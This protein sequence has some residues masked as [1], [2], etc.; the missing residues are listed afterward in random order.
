MMRELRQISVLC[1]LVWSLV[2]ASTIAQDE[3]ET[4]GSLGTGELL[5][6]EDKPTWSELYA[7]V[8]AQ[9]QSLEPR[10]EELESLSRPLNK[11]EKEELAATYDRLKSQFDELRDTREEAIE[12]QLQD[13]E[14]SRRILTRIEV[15]LEK[16]R[17]FA[18][19]EEARNAPQVESMISNF[20]FYG[21][22][23]ARGFSHGDGERTLDDST[24][25]SVPGSP[26]IRK[27]PRSPRRF[28][29]TSKR[30]KN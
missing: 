13:A 25:V 12:Q 30:P 9:L 7:V 15:L 4:P 17:T 8:M 23:R 2:P 20:A 19:P 22:I 6:D 1:V 21:S 5:L 28:E 24:S 27:L 3:Q 16:T 18:A 26:P 14:P 11:E 10:L 29:P